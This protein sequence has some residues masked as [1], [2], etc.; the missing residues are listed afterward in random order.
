MACRRPVAELIRPAS[1][2]ELSGHSN[3]IG[4]EIASASAGSKRALR[5]TLTIRDPAPA[6]RRLFQITGLEEVLTVEPEQ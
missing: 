4:R 3:G 5:H 2:G 1:G 6:T